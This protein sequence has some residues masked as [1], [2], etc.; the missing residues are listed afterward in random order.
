M[1]S[2]KMAELKKESAIVPT[3]ALHELHK[4]HY[5][6]LG[7]ETAETRTNI[8]IKSGFNI[9][10]LDVHVAKKAAELRCKYAEV[11]TADAVIAGTAI[12]TKS[13]RVVTDDPHFQRIKEIKTE[14]L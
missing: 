10:D 8:I 5:Q 11:P 3:I 4:H 2:E 6:T 9:A 14:W 13:F 1:A 7:R 12:L